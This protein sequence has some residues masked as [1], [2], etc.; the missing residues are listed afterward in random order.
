MIRVLIAEDQALVRGALAT[1]LSLEDGVEVVAEAGDG[2]TAIDL[3]L[4]VRPDVA[5]LDIEMPKLSGLDVVA[6]LT[7]ELPGCRCLIVTTFARAGYLQRAVKAGAAGYILKDA[8]V[9][10][11]VSAIRTVHAG[12]RVMDPQLMVA[13][14][15][16]ENPLLARET[17]L[18]RLAAQGLSTRELARTFC[19]T[20]GTVRNYLSEIMAKL[21]VS[22]RQEAVE[23]ARRGGWL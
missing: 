9:A 3:A 12:G 11:V 22:T 5:L 1:L 20:E 6:R 7:G 17:D 13:A 15:T 2:Q 19:L 21:G 23:A 8:A 10:D 14:L 4:R 18:L 16:S